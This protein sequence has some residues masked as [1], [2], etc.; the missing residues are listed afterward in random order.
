MNRV[1]LADR[2]LVGLGQTQ[3]PNL[4]RLDV[5]RHRA[6]HVLDGHSRVRTVLVEH[7]DRVDAE[8][9]QAGVDDLADVFGTRVGPERPGES[10]LR[11]DHDVVTHRSQGA[12]EQPLALAPAVHLGGVEHRHAEIV[13]GTDR[14]NRFDVVGRAVADCRAHRAV[15]QG[16]DR[17]S[18]FAECA[19]FHGSSSLAVAD[20]CVRG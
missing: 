9:A 20:Q 8:V 18:L 17:G 3:I 13:C 15:A 10:E 5:L 6:D 14:G 11:G 19:F 1:R 4:A 16:G 12:A 2:R 7:I